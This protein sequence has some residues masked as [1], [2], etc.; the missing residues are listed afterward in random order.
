[1]ADLYVS[2]N[3]SGAQLHDDQIV[4]RVA[5]VLSVHRSGGTSLC[6]ELTESVVMEDPA[7]AAVILTG[8]RRSA[9]GSPSTTSGPSTR[10]S[11]T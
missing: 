10:R 1:M 5:D 11:P 3:L 2:V 4:D 8:L 7:A 9:C 6:L